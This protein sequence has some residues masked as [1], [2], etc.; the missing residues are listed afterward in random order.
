MAD[1]PNLTYATTHEDR[2][3]ERTARAMTA[4]PTCGRP[5][6]VGAVVC[7]GECWRGVDGLKASPLPAG[8]WLDRQPWLLLDEA[9][10]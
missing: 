9:V 7:W 4:C 1:S 5:K 2:E 3:R 10:R 8:V 6:T